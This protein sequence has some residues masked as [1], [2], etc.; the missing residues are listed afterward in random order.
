MTPVPSNTWFAS[1][2]YRSFTIIQD[3]GCFWEISE[4]WS[5]FY[6]H[7]LPVLHS[8]TKPV[9]DRSSC[10]ASPAKIV[11][12]GASTTISESMGL[13]LY[14]VDCHCCRISLCF[15]FLWRYLNSSNYK[16]AQI[17]WV[18]VSDKCGKWRAN[19][20]NVFKNASY[21]LNW[22]WFFFSCIVKW[23]EFSYSSLAVSV[24]IFSPRPPRRSGTNR[25]IHP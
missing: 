11:D 12:D 4:P 10:D 18:A 7:I 5:K 21:W 9:V 1:S 16:E 6:K 8:L 20:A 24:R 17:C 13:L 3:Y 15:S 23:R 14:S 22:I 19:D 2:S 25:S